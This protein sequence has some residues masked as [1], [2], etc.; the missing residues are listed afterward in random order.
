[1]SAVRA[2]VLA[3]AL[4]LGFGGAA[5]AM[6]DELPT[7][8]LTFKADGTFEPQRLEVSAGRFKIELS[9]ESNEPVEFESIP[10]RKEK[11]LGPGVKSFAAITI[12][13]PGEYPFFDDFHQQVTG[14]L[15]VKPN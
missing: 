10:L 6:A 9:N 14:T 3:A 4:L 13:R 15:V 7:F 12:S 2:P 5:Q 8:Q 11:V 1:M